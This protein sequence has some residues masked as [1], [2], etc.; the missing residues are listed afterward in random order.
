[1]GLGQAVQKSVSEFVKYYP[2][3]C[4]CVLAA[5]KQICSCVL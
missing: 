4:F 2:E 3:G 5:F 1:M